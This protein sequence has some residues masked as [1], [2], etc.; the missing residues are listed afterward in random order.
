MA[1]KPKKKSSNE[2]KL[3][4]LRELN[5]EAFQELKSAA[6][7]AGIGEE[8]TK[9]ARHMVDDVLME[10]VGIKKRQDKRAWMAKN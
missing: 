10:R 3:K 5:R 7:L 4:W 2:R 8:L 6:D 1:T 9:L